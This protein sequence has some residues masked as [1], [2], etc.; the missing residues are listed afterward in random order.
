[1]G[2]LIEHTPDVTTFAANIVV[3]FA[4]LTAA[5]AGAMISVKKLKKTWVESINDETSPKS[6]QVVSATIMETQTLL[7]LSEANRALCHELSEAKDAMNELRH[8]MEL[9][10]IARGSRS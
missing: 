9:T 4:A 3:F 1:M 6:T 5:V 10:R 7:M 8:E 2:A